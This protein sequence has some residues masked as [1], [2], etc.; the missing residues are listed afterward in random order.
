MSVYY[1]SMGKPALSS[2]VVNH[3][4]DLCQ[5]GLLTALG[6]LLCGREV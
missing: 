3:T 6:S 4:K 2:D 5:V 1:H